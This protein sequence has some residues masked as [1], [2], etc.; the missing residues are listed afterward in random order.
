MNLNSVILVGAVLG[1]AY[2]FGGSVKKNISAAALDLVPNLNPV[3]L[4]NTKYPKEL[5]L[6]L[7]KFPFRFTVFNNTQETQKVENAKFDL[8][9]KKGEDFKMIG[10]IQMQPNERFVINTEADIVFSVSLINKEIL[11][12]LGIKIFDAA[13]SKEDNEK[14]AMTKLQ[15]LLSALKGK[16][17]FVNGTMVLNGNE[18]PY[19]QKITL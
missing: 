4:L 18:I 13:K 16:E 17:L 9:I 2:L 6:N 19:N 7:I 1:G 12:A 5:T 14:N 10:F 11:E 8:L 15:D 3:D